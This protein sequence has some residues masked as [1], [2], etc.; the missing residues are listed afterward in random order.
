M[1]GFLI[2]RGKLDT[3]THTGKTR[4]RHREKTAPYE[5]KRKASEETNLLTPGS[6]PSGLQN[7][8]KIN[9]HF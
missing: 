7:C 5:T 1:T 6:Q 2:R 4:G 3:N 9:L 8:E